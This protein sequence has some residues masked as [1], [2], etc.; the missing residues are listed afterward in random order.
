MTQTHNY[1]EQIRSYFEKLYLTLNAI[2]VEEI[3]KVLELFIDAYKTKKTIFVVGNG[4]SSATASHMVTDFN[5]GI[6]YGKKSKFRM[7]ALTDNVPSMMAIGNDIH[8]ED[9]FVEQLK[10][11]FEPGDLVLGI[12]GSGNSKNVIKAIQYANENGGT[13]IGWSGY[14]GGV[15]LKIAKYNIHVNVQDMQI[16]EDAH[17]ILNHLMMQI[18]CTAIE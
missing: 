1:S 2:K 8:F 14:T 6:S 5:K 12:S 18:L 9:I 4:G 16:A 7:M 13:T 17:L 11:Y 10:S 15:L 3:N